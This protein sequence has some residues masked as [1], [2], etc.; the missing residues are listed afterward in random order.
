MYYE[1]DRQLGTQF[2]AIGQV[3]YMF[4]ES[5]DNGQKGWR[6]G[7]VCQ[8]NVGNRFSPNIIA[9]PLTTALKRV[10]MPTHVILD[11]PMS[12][13]PKTSMAL[14]EN[15]HYLSKDSIGDY[16]TTL[17][18]EYMRKIAIAV[19]TATSLVAYLSL[20]EIAELRD[21]AIQ[22]NKTGYPV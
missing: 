20:D 19:I 16:L 4:F 22:M 8:N 7:I 1:N 5:C 18:E 9:V 13:L 21:R 17:P 14:C 15:L 6:P 12:G 11:S 2:P 10:D 3:F